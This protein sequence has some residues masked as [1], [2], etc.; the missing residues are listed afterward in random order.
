MCSTTHLEVQYNGP[1]Q[2][3]GQL[4][5]AVHNVLGAYVDQLDLLVAQE[6]QSHLCILQHMESHFTLLA[7]L[8]YMKMRTKI[9]W[10]ERDKNA[11]KPIE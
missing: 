4:W 8:K 3:Q 2:A 7:W 10:R 5:I 9:R 6:V 1:D 11:E